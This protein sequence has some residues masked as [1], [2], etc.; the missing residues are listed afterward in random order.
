MQTILNYFLCLLRYTSTPVSTS[1][2]EINV[3]ISY[4]PLKLLKIY[5]KIY[6]KIHI[7]DMYYSNHF[8]NIMSWLQFRLLCLKRFN[9]VNSILSFHILFSYIHIIWN[10]WSLCGTDYWR[11]LR[12]DTCKLTRYGRE[13]VLWEI[14]CINITLC[15]IFTV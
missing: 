6:I 8:W 15:V 11:C 13:P 5:I 1:F 3:F 9:I 2:T 4:H 7:K 12:K 10:F 14:Q